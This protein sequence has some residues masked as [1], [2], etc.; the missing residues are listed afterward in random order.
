MG[1]RGGWDAQKYGQGYRH[2]SQSQA[3]YE[4]E[5]HGKGYGKKHGKEN[6]ADA[7]AV[8]F[9]SYEMMPIPGGR[10]GS[11]SRAARASA[12]REE[13]EDNLEIQQNT[14]DLTKYVQKMINVIRRSDGKLRKCDK[15]KAD[16]EAQWQDYQKNLQKAFMK[17]CQR[18]KEKMAQVRKEQ[19]EHGKMKENAIYKL[20][21]IIEDPGRA[22]EQDIPEE[23][24]VAMEEWREL[25]TLTADPW[26]QLP[27]DCWPTRPRPARRLPGDSFLVR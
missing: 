22:I 19:A 25:V 8:N 27:G 16:A 4:K 5:W 24:D 26:E 7:A 3:Y 9:P 13:T 14:G 23:M 20:R 11:G 1:K 10:N 21:S 2:Y 6:Q 17:D 12:S 18:Y 15:D